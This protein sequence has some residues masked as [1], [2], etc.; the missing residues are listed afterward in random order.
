[1]EHC[2]NTQHED[3]SMLLRWDV[4]HPGQFQLMPTPLPGWDGVTYV[5]SVALPTFRTGDDD[6]EITKAT[7]KNRWP[8]PTA[9]P[10]A[11]ASR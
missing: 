8:T 4:E 3:N 9:P 6:D 1:M 7:T 2:H 5:T 11:T 10:A